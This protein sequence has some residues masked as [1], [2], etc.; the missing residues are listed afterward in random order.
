MEWNRDEWQGRTKEQV[1][2]NYKTLSLFIKFFL[3]TII[4]MVLLSL[5]GVVVK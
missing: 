1:E 3:L 4:I 2:R 5:F